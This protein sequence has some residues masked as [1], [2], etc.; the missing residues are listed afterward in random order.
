MSI[1]K[2]IRF[3]KWY[4]GRCY[5][6]FLCHD[7]CGVNVTMAE[8]VKIV[9]PQNLHVGRDVYIDFGAYVHCGGLSWCEGKG[10]VTIGKGSYIGPECIVF[11]MGGVEIGEYVMVSPNVVI[12]SVQHP[13]RDTSKPMYHQPR[14]YEKV[15]IEDDVYIGSNAVITP[16]VTIGECA[17]VG[18]G[19]IV[20]KDID[21][22]GIALGIPA[23][24]V[25]YRKPRSE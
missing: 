11:G 21:P 13:Y 20:T 7:A 10:S 23:R 9:S 16:G 22:Y 5:A 18:A 17:V 14:I 6:E 8:N 1:T 19:S 15:V 2:W 25:E 12:T 24:I 4:F 3:A